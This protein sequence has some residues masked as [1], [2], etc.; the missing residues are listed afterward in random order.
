MQVLKIID[1]LDNNEEEC[2]RFLDAVQLLY[3]YILSK[4]GET[5]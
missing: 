4:Q 1:G 5:P 2:K 3:R